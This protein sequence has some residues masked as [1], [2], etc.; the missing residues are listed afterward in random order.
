Y[1]AAGSGT[2]LAAALSLLRRKRR[3]VVFLV[4]DFRDPACESALRIAARKHD[5]IAVCVSDPAEE[6]LPAVGLVRLADAE[7]GGAWLVNTADLRVRS[8]YAAVARAR[9]FALHDLLRAAGA[10]R[11]DVSTAGGHLEALVE[12]FHQR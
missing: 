11:V 8:A 6:I 9:R 7:A 2:S 4:S 3:A 5:L 12:F 10:D 1:E